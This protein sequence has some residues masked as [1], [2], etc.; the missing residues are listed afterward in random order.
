MALTDKLRTLI[1]SKL[2]IK[3]AIEAKGVTVGDS[4]LSEYARKITEISGAGVMDEILASYSYSDSVNNFKWMLEK[5]YQITKEWTNYNTPGKLKDLYIVPYI[6]KPSVICFSDCSNLTFLPDMDC[7]NNP[8]TFYAFNGCNKLTEINLV[9]FDFGTISGYANRHSH[10]FTGC[11]SL[12]KITGL[13]GITDVGL[14]SMFIGCDILDIP[15]IDTSKC[16]GLNQY[17]P[18]GTS[19]TQETFPEIDASSIPENTKWIL[20]YSWSGLN[21]KNMTFAGVISCNVQIF[22]NN[23][24]K[25]SLLSLFNHLKDHSGG[26]THTIETGAVNLAKLSIEE[27]AIA[28]NKNWTLT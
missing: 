24:T 11:T 3:T 2:A 15:Y 25:E 10:M 27:K 18:M 19:A 1:A 28:T 16:T 4:P 14:D 17:F 23:L 12:R 22:G 20:S 6:P 9:N 7:S 5:S 8:Y 21:V 13:K 26:T